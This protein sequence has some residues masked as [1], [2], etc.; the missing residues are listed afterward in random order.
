MLKMKKALA[1]FAV[2]GVLAASAGAIARNDLAA[3][4]TR[5]PGEMKFV[6][7]AV[8]PGLATSVLVG[9]PSKAGVY[10]VHTRLPANLKLAAHSHAEAWRIATVLSGTL[11]YSAGDTFDESKLKAL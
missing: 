1:S 10:A 6:A 4:F 3:L 11:Y 5:T 7:D 2:A 9:D 8:Q